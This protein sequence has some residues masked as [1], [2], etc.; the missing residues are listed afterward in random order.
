M[1]SIELASPRTIAIDDRGRKFLLTLKR[2]DRK[3]WLRYFDGIVNVSE[4]QNGQ[5]VNRYDNSAAKLELVQNSLID[6]KGYPIDKD[7]IT[8]YENWQQKLPLAHRLAVGEQLV[9][10]ERGSES[11]DETFVL[12]FETV[13]LNVVWGAD[14]SGIMRKYS[15]LRHCF[16]T[17]TEEHQ[18]RLSRDS[19]RSIIV[20]G[21][22]RGTTRWLGIQPTLVELYDEL[23]KS[24]DGYAVN[25]VD[26]G[27]D[28]EAIVGEMDTYHKV[29]AAD[30]LFSPAEVAEPEEVK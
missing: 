8:L 17:P 10:V 9:N 14:D 21:S 4:N 11:E 26:L 12:G 20:G 29:A 27:S 19:S 28:R 1:A 30:L 16:N 2:I 18:A 15:G 24:V 25:G 3:A 6:A 23:I 13:I 7:S 5:R 22:R